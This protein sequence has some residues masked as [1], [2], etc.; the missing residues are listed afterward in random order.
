MFYVF[1][2]LS[3]D[4][5][6]T[7]YG[8]SINDLP[9]IEKRITIQGGANVAT[10][11]LIT[12]KGVMTVVEDADFDI[13]N[14]HPVFLMH[15]KNGFITVETKAANPEKVATNMTARDESAPLTADDFNEDEVPTTSKGSKKK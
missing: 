12:P 7:V 10:K 1:S 2:T 11:H 13:L 14:A 5:D 15:Q 9:T 6:Y 4:V 3:T 8:E